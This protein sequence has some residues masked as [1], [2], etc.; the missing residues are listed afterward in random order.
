MKS[1][2]DT[3]FLKIDKLNFI[4]PLVD[5]KYNHIYKYFTFLKQ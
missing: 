1:I 5:L 2:K 4:T 3:T